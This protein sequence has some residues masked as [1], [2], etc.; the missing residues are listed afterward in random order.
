M[1]LSLYGKEP[2]E[3]R[4]YTDYINS[5]SEMELFIIVRKYYEVIRTSENILREKSKKITSYNTN[6]QEFLYSLDYSLIAT[7][8]FGTKIEYNPNGR[9]KLTTEFKKWYDSWQNYEANLD[10][11]TRKLYYTYR[12][13]G[14]SL[15]LFSLDKQL[16][17]KDIDIIEETRETTYYQSMIKSIKQATA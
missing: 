5:C 8:R 7:N 15:E 1:E 2:G 9:I 11:E 12:R 14:K 17:S 3:L 4:E 16:T 6:Y 10:N 13:Q